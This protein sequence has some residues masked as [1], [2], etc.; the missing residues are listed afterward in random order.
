MVLK[1]DYDTVKLQ[2]VTYI[3]RHFYDVSDTNQNDVTIVFQFQ[4]PLCKI[5]V[6]LLS[7]MCIC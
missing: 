7:V 1:I 5:L 6:V 3:W 2:K 4:A